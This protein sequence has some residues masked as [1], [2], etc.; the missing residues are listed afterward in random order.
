MTM[1]HQLKRMIRAVRRR[2]L[3]LRFCRLY[4]TVFGW[5]ALALCLYLAATRLLP[6]LWPLERLVPWAAGLGVLWLC[7]GLW[8]RRVRLMDAALEADQTLGIKER[9]STALALGEPK[10]E[11]E[12]AVMED[13]LAWARR[14]RPG[15]AFTADLRRETTL[16]LAPVL[17]MA[18]VWWLMPQYNLLAH[19]QEEKKQ[20][21]IALET[22][23]RAATELEQLA[24][25]ANDPAKIDKPA[26]V[27][28][29]QRELNMLARNLA[30]QKITEQQALA[31]MEKLKDAMRERRAELEKQL[32]KPNNLETKGQGK[33]TKDIQ[34]AVKRGDFDKAAS[35]MDELAEKLKKNEMSEQDKAALQQELKAMAEKLGTDTPLGD[36]LA[37]AC[38]KMGNGQ[39]NEAL[40]D[41]EMSAEQLRDLKAMLA[42]LKDLEAL[43]YDMDARKLAQ[44]CQMC[45][46]G[47]NPSSC[48][49]SA[50]ALGQL[51][52]RK[53][54]QAG[55]SRNQGAGMGK[56]GIGQGSVAAK[57]EGQTALQKS[58]VQGQIQPG[59]IIARMKVP[60]S[61]APGEVTTQYEALRLEYSQRAEDVI[62]KEV[63][64]LE[65]KTR[66]RDYFSAIKY[67][68]QEAAGQKS[69]GD[70]NA[71]G[72]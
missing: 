45:K 62:N 29:V 27:E 6:G 41:M 21:A 57:E 55:D 4:L 48:T 58:R 61:Q 38:D 40:A 14:I 60:G 12:Q 8:L 24:R 15:R 9:L 59:K 18:L 32:A 71:S 64:P 33:F 5:L 47:D 63:M 49:G 26:S 70:T 13:A 35:L 65:Y 3:W 28:R 54:W 22:R 69:T 16:A 39:F 72:E 31:R 36:S 46:A 52:G 10:N 43:D 2:L 11:P 51:A 1:H 30:E 50:A 56:D 42:E 44:A 17:V 25:E 7:A 68:G 53:P 66:V 67:A 34:K 20:A 37:K 19:G 23:Q